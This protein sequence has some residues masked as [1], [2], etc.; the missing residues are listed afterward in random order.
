MWWYESSVIRS[1]KFGNLSSETGCGIAAVD[2]NS[3]K[4][5]RHKTNLSAIDS[6]LK[7]DLATGPNDSLGGCVRLPGL[8]SV[9]SRGLRYKCQIWFRL[10]QSLREKI[11]CSLTVIKVELENFHAHFFNS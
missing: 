11:V 2:N 3:I 1:N 4:T 7:R 9:M 5:S 10:P 6:A 8:G